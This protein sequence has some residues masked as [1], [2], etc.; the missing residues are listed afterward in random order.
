VEWNILKLAIKETTSVERYGAAQLRWRRT[1]SPPLLDRVTETGPMSA[2]SVTIR[3]DPEASYRLDQLAE[4]WGCSKSDV[5]R[6]AID[7]LGLL[8]DPSTLGD[9]T[10]LSLLGDKATLAATVGDALA[11]APAKAEP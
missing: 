10:V 11:T 4:Q 2:A 9:P 6:N 8:L 7:T 1:P 5:V 3:L